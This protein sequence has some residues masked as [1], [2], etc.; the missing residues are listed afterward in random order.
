MST[1]ELRHEG[2]RTI[3]PADPSAQVAVIYDWAGEEYEGYA[4]GDVEELF[5]FSGQHAYSDRTVW[6]E[7]DRLMME[8]F[9]T[10]ATT[11]S[12]LDAGCGPGTWLRRAV[13]RAREIGFASITAR[14][15]DIAGQQISRARVLARDVADLPGVRLSFQIADL[16]HPLPEGD[17]TVDV[18][19]CLYSVLSH[20][21]R[22]ER[23]IAMRELTR[24]TAGAV[25][26]TVRSIGSVASGFVHPVETVRY[27]RQ[28]HGRDVCEIELHD[29]SR[30]V[31]PMHLFS[32]E[33]LKRDLSKFCAV[34]TVMA[35]DLFHTRFSPDPRWNPA[36][37]QIDGRIARSL[38]AMEEQFR[39]SPEFL[40]RGV[41]ILM[42]ARAAPK[43][44]GQPSLRIAP[45][46]PGFRQ[47]Q[48][49]AAK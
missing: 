27:L 41:H 10:G 32:A 5:S 44:D 49:L 28:D 2:L 22:S 31:F 13:A 43:T 45:V 17:E 7:I 40:D 4:D 36:S 15:F 8:R 39:T 23:A 18:T 34:E 20:I 19:L 38:R 46:L 9:R 21:P 16:T 29:D 47:T 42:I 12:I 14:G 48:A 33:E 11:I 26:V 3:A 37:M 24:V 30:S 25:V 1:A 35:L 6:S